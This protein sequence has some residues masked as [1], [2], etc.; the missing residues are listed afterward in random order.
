MLTKVPIFAAVY[1][2]L[3]INELLLLVLVIG[4]PVFRYS[5]P[6]ELCSGIY[7]VFFYDAEFEY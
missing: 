5:F 7:P 4:V 2:I 1:Y 3:A 6:G